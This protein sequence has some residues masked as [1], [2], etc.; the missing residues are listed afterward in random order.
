[1]TM[2][3]CGRFMNGLGWVG[4]VGLWRLL[5]RSCR[6]CGGFWGLEDFGGVSLSVEFIVSVLGNVDFFE[7]SR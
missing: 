2:V 1:M 4:V 3:G 5:S 6:E 7:E